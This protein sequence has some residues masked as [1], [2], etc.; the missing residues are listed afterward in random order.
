VGLLAARAVAVAPLADP[1]GSPLPPQLNLSAPWPY[2]LFAPVFTLWDGV[3]ML[4]M[5]RLKG[6]LLGLPLLYLAWRIA[7]G[8]RRRGD[9]AGPAR[10]LRRELVAL[11]AATGA[12]I[13]FVLAGALWHRPMLALAGVP[14]GEVVADFHSHTNVSHD[15]RGTA[16]RGYDIA[17][18]LRWHRRAGFDAAFIT[19]H[20]TIARGP[21]EIDGTARCPG[22]EVSAWR[23]HV[24]LLGDS[25]PVDRSRYNK[26][27][28][29]LLHLLRESDSVYGALS[30]ASLPEYRRHQWGRLDTL[31]AAGLDG[32]ELV[33]AAPQANQLT[34]AEQNT[35]IAL[36]RKRG[37]FL[38]GVSDHHGWGATSMVWNLVRIPA[39][40]DSR[41]ICSAI[42]ARLRGGGFLANRIIE[43]HHLRAD[44][45]WPMWLTPVAVIWET[46][47]GMGWAMTLSW[48][49]WTW[50]VWGIRRVLSG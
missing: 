37:R 12:F 14:A 29:A 24:V 44:S 7:I 36:A 28:S 35:V 6:L 27:L 48:I 20:N 30:V 34:R 13:L 8:I 49:A 23:A 18:N 15:V 16:M 5:S 26:S 17:A 22:I 33:N 43:R 32:F 3:S 31:I 4:S 11:L 10:T 38:V 42:L 25:M 19:D 41:E 47:R 2:L 50:L 1:L 9:P 45:A 46:W 39:G 21:A 40:R